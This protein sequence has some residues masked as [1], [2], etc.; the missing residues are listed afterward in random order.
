MKITALVLA[1]GQSH[2]MGQDKR[3]LEY[4]GKPLIRRAFEAT[5]AISDELWVLIA[6]HED[7][8]ILSPLLN[9]DTR[10]LLDE[11]PN[12]GPLAALVNALPHVKSKYALLL[13]VD[14]PLVTRSFLQKMKSTLEAQAPSPDA[15]VPLWQ[16]IPQVACAFYRQS[17][18]T[19]LKE[20]FLKGERSLRRWVLSSPKGRVQWLHEEDWQRWEHREVFLNVNTPQDY[21]RLLQLARSPFEK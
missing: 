9:R 15:F 21:Q 20:A 11:H 5:Q 4:Q 17:L 8:Q 10:F 14:Y 3:L 13:A 19:E 12:S 18:H 7:Q 6:S 1:G 16:G 2:R